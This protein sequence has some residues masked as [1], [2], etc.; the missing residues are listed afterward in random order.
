MVW[1]CNNKACNK[2]ISIRENSWFSHSNLSLEKIIK[3]TYYWVWKMPEYYVRIQLQIGS[4]ETLVD[5]YSFGREVCLCRLEDNCE[6]IGGE[7]V[8]VE[9][10][11]SKFGKRKYNRGKRVEG[12]W[13]FGGIEQENKS[14]CFMVC[15]EDRSADTLVPLIVKY[16]A[17]KR[18]NYNIRLLACI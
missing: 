16:I 17:I 3:L 18:I 14:K 10:D 1:R 7:N 11:E 6:Q 4:T 15:V 8:I 5:W 13:V 2:K 12:Q 9:I